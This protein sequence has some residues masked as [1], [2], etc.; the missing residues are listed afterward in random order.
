MTGRMLVTA[1][2]ILCAACSAQNT[3]TFSVRNKGLLIDTGSQHANGC[4][5]ELNVWQGQRVVFE[6]RIF[7]SCARYIFVSDRGA[8]A[9]ATKLYTVELMFDETPNGYVVFAIKGAP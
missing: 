9:D 5:K 3:P 1:L 2:T 8:N 7:H 6:S 4:V